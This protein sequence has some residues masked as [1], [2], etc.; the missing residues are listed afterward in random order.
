MG[1]VPNVSVLD[2]SAFYLPFPLYIALYATEVPQVLY[3]YMLP[4]KHVL[5]GHC[6]GMGA[7]LTPNV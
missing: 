1:I 4:W 6:M 5:T 7:S 2:S 3:T